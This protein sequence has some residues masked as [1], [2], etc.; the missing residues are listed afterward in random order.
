[1]L[2][3]D[4]YVNVK[5]DK[6]DKLFKLLKLAVNPKNWKTLYKENREIV[7]Y[8]IF[9]IGTTIVSF[10]AYYL[11]R[12]LF[13]SKESVPTFLQWI[14][15]LTDFFGVESSTALPVVLSWICAVTF[16]YITNRLW[17]FESKVTGIASAL[18]EFFSFYASR[19]LTLGVDLLLMYLLVDLTGISGGWY[20]LFARCVVSVFVLTLNYI[21]SKLFVFR[22]KKPEQNEPDEKNG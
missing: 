12:W 1:M 15:S 20:E 22:K 4:G 11:F 18:K 10:A 14:Y 7:N 8:V 6:M 21:L 16:A 2:Y 19:L 17:V 3:N 9:G 13:P 5:E